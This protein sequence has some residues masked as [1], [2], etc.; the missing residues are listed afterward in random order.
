MIPISFIF[1]MMPLKLFKKCSVALSLWLFYIQSYATANAAPYVANTAITSPTLSLFKM[2][3]GL[4]V[5]VGIMVLLAWFVK[6][7][8][9]ANPQQNAIAK[10]VSSV[11]VGSRER[12]VV[13]EVADRWIVVGVAPGQV[14]AIATLDNV[15]LIAHQAAGAEK[16]TA[17]SVMN[18]AVNLS[19]LTVARKFFKPTSIT[20][21]L[22]QKQ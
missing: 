20:R 2:F 8:G 21:S 13:I 9:L 17:S 7:L 11:S 22:K 14:N 3:A 18:T 10:V 19:W 1:H 15:P 4:V 16:P 5:V 6:R 12:V